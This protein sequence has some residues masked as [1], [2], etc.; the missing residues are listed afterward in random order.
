M[1]CVKDL[2]TLCPLEENSNDTQSRL[3]ECATE[4][5]IDN[6]PELALDD[7]EYMCY[8][9]ADNVRHLEPVSTNDDTKSSTRRRTELDRLARNGWKR[10]ST[11]TVLGKRNLYTYNGPNGVVETSLK[12][13]MH[14]IRLS[15][16]VDKDQGRGERLRR[17]KAVTGECNKLKYFTYIDDHPGTP[18]PEIPTPA[19]STLHSVLTLEPRPC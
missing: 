2:L 12:R 3:S 13:V 6:F 15:I 11:S 18:L 9:A 19:P 10:D 8:V 4:E 16:I 1:L 14:Q 7:E 5:T 17:C